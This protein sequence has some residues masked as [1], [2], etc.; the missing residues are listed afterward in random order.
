[1]ADN[2]GDY[3][4]ITVCV[5]KDCH[6]VD[7]RNRDYGYFYNPCR[8]CVSEKQL[9]E[10]YKKVGEIPEKVMTP[11]INALQNVIHAHGEAFSLCNKL[12][13]ENKGLA[14]TNFIK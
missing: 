5:G 10:K 12:L 9:I 14:I 8:A 4:L 2:Y 6:Y 1:M 13:N 7:W 3:R 11:I